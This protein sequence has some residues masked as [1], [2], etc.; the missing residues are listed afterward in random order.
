MP[1]SCFDL[2]TCTGT[3]VPVPVK[4]LCPSA[5]CDFGSIIS[6][7][8]WASLGIWA[9]DG[10]S[11]HIQKGFITRSRHHLY[12]CPRPRSYRYTTLSI[13]QPTIQQKNDTKKCQHDTIQ[14]R[15]IQTSTISAIWDGPER[16]NSKLCAC[17]PGIAAA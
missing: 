1:L 6:R 17:A 7:Q 9:S 11:C 14:I 12:G 2:V 13:D 3:V 5:V 10:S 8:A 16:A 15:Q 4:A